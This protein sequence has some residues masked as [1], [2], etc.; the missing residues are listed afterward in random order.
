MNYLESLAAEFYEYKGNFVRR[1]V[2]TRKRPRGGYDVEIDVLAYQPKSKKLFHVET[3]G[4]ATTWKSQREIILKKKF[5]LSKEEYE[6][7]LSCKISKIKKVMIIGW[8]K[9]EQAYFDQE[10]KVIPIP[11]FINEVADKLKGK[12]PTKQIVPE[13]YPLLRSIQMAQHYIK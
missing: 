12:I 3:S 1:N 8:A 2:K 6:A 10:I 4:A 11:A 13:H 7:E 5:D 9:T